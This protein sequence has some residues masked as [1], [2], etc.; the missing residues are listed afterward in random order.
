M[1][2][3]NISKQPVE[4][5]IDKKRGRIVEID[6]SRDQRIGKLNNK[7]ITLVDRDS[8]CSEHAEKRHK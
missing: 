5:K 4:C 7:P 8:A 2:Q 1:A 6:K 3:K